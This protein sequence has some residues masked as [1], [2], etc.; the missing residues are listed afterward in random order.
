MRSLIIL[1]SVV[2]NGCYCCVDP[3]QPPDNT[4]A[5]MNTT[6]SP[7][8]L[9]NVEQ[10]AASA[11]QR[12]DLALWIEARRGVNVLGLEHVAP[13][14]VEQVCGLKYLPL[15]GDVYRVQER[16]QRQQNRQYGLEYNQRV[17]PH[18]LKKLNT[19]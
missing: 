4:S 8:S 17:I 13:K 18:C 12:G 10:Q 16:E 11:I 14:Q 15:S 3:V 1:V 19:P 7:L 9:Q 5:G 6:N 2:L